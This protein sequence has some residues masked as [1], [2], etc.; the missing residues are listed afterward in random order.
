MT[1]VERYTAWI[2]E[3]IGFN[4]RA[5]QNSNALSQFVIEDLCRVCPALD[6]D[7][8]EEQVV[9][10]LNAPVATRVARRNVDLVF[11]EVVAE[12]P[13]RQVRLAIEHKTIMTAHG[14]AR[15]NRYG[16]I[17][18]YANHLHNHWTKAIAASI[19]AINMNPN[20]LNP[21]PF[22]RTIERSY[23]NMM[24]VVTDTINIFTNVPL[25]DLEDEPN[26]Q[27]EAVGIVVL[28]Y[29]GANPAR[30]VTGP[31]APQAGEPGHYETFLRRLCELYCRRYG[32]TR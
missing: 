8:D 29:D 5:Q 1:A 3:N 11:R 31:P 28:D 23:T 19:V 27:P 26:D 15:W 30:L 32:N 24:K 2:N 22:A 4:P 25:R 20:Y 7:L 18:A 9:V 21:D 12:G 14:K 13:L 6:R 16:D 17:I 10:R